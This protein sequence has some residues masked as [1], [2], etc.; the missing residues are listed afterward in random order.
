MASPLEAAI[1][2]YL[3]H[4]RD[5][6][7]YS[8]H[9][10]AAYAAD[11]ADL[12]GFADSRGGVEAGSPAAVP[13]TRTRDPARAPLAN[14]AAGPAAELDLAL[15][16]DWLWD[17]DQRGLARATLA[18]RAATA[19]GFAAWLATSGRAASDA[20]AR[21]RAPKAQRTLPRVLTREAAEGLL[22]DLEAAAATGEPNALRDHAVVEL[23]YAAALRVSELVG[24][25]VDDL[26][27]SARTVR[28][29]GKGSKERVV[30]YGAPAARALDRYLD[31]GRPV[32]LARAAA[33]G[34]P[35]AGGSSTAARP[36]NGGSSSR[37]GHAVFLGARGG[38]LN[39]RSVHR[40]VAGLLAEIPGGGPAGPHAL[41][42]TAA[43]HLLDGGAELRAVQE[44][45]GHASL[46][47]TQIYTHVSAERLKQSY[48]TAHPRA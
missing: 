10:V 4:V 25:D 46:G 18:R 16:R 20:G 48:R 21:L 44:F 19:R 26:D 11:L 38:R 28:V 27:R 6:R 29:L 39:P 41:R 14:A 24:L 32:L 43:T 22:G 9:T 47:T 37:P 31:L 8:A 36:S 15:L 12:A 34:S 35:S 30:P 3:A 1:D 42:H 17:A 40:L 13:S 7:R 2:D 45:L 5:E 33:G 23:L